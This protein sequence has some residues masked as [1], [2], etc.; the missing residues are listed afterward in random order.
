M[1]KTEAKKRIKKLQEVIRRH[2][3]LLHVK[4][5]QEISEEALDSLKHE[6]TQL[7]ELFPDLITP[8]SPTQRV[9]GKPLNKFQKRKHTLPMRSLHDVFSY[10]ELEEW[11]AR[12][13]KLQPTGRFEY[14]AELKM[15]GLALSLVYEGGV[16]Q[17]GTTRGDGSTG[18]DV[19]QNVRT[20]QAIP[21][22]MHIDKVRDAA[23]RKK[24][25]GTVI[26]RGEVYMRL[27][28]LEQLNK[29]L[30]KSGE[31]EIANPRN[32]AAGSIRQLDSSLTA[33]RKLDF[34]AYDIPTDLGLDSHKEVHELAGK[35]GFPTAKQNTFCKDLGEV[36]KVYERML[37]ERDALQFWTDGLVVNIDSNKLMSSLGVVGKGPRGSR[38]WKYPAEEATTTV[39]GISVQVG[40]TGV[41]TP[42]A[43]LEP[44]LIG[45]TTVQRAS[46]HNM[47][48]I[49]RLE[50]KIGDTVIVKKAGD[51][52][53]KVVKV[54][55]ELRTGK[56]KNFHMPNE[57]PVCGG[58]VEQPEGEVNYYCTNPECV[59]RHRE[60][61]YYFIS[62]AGF[63]IDG[64]G[65]K[66]IDRLFEAGLVTT[67]ADLFTL[68]EA[69]IFELEGFKETS[70]K[71]I[72]SAIAEKKEIPLNRFLIAL[73]IRHVGEETSFDVAKRFGSLSTLRKASKEEIEA[74]PNV[75]G[76]VAES[77]F[78]YLNSTEG[79]REIDGLLGV[80]VTVKDAE[81]VG[82][83][84]FDGM[85]VVVTGSLT[86][87]SRDKLKE[88]VRRE[89]GN[90]AGSVSK[91]TDL[92]IVGEN[93][94]SKYEKAKELGIPTMDEKALKKKLSS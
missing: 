63:D 37:K 18:E 53:P 3:Y 76:V 90:P 81:Q 30:R 14:Y 93:P 92:V 58:K 57:C 13:R 87:F 49:D 48:E 71:N 2:R 29:K 52:I 24:L 54:L 15:D 5:K 74:I 61:V 69:D 4:D 45:G 77:L 60:R 38:A 67:F 89:G 17:Y 88:I 66:I 73:G 23:L 40:R 7:E 27:D 78:A 51:V 16:L 70:A 36:K 22:K 26:V 42:V 55:T 68:K 94:G 46:L 21:L 64:L 11:Q 82:G 56:E 28:V 50:L 20:I 84:L 65:P 10:E 43:E 59:S 6:L 85:T 12:L 25:E 34:M 80:G 83:K 47:D 86:E 35:L 33:S 75:G 1:T 79:N 39:N 32:G 9:A 8:D 62:K 19:T 91:K 31:K 72:I 44:V 41:L